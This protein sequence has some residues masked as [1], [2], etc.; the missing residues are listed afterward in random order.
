MG[1]RREGWYHS[2]MPSGAARLVVIFWGANDAA[3]LGQLPFLQGLPLDEYQL[4]LKQMIASIRECGNRDFQTPTEVILV[5]PPPVDDQCWL[6]ERKQTFKAFNTNATEEEVGAVSLDRTNEITRT[7]AAAL[8]S[9]AQEVKCPLVDLYESMQA[10]SEGESSD[11]PHRKYF[12]D[13]L[14]FSEAGND[15]MFRA[16]RKTIKQHLPTLTPFTIEKGTFH[17]VPD[18]WCSLLQSQTSVSGVM[19]L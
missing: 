15:F 19:L 13:G 12:S 1:K 10:S 2:D 17:V 7:Y 5:T 14:H 18:S 8:R 4:N 11:V 16:L 6:A 9:V 3:T